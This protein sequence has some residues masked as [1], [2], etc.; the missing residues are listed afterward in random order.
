MFS[1]WFQA[2]DLAKYE[3]LSETPRGAGCTITG[4]IYP[5]NYSCGFQCY[6]AEWAVDYSFISNTLFYYLQLIMPP[7]L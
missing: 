4:S 1:F 6:V 3:A 2:V 5:S 7:S